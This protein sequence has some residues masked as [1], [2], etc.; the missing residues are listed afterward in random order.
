MAGKTAKKRGKAKSS[1]KKIAKKTKSKIK[2][3]VKST[4]R[5]AKK[6]SK[7]SKITKRKSK[8]APA[9]KEFFL[10]NG[11]KVKNYEQLAK[12]MENLEDHVF[13][14]HVNSERNDFAN[15][16]KDVFNDIALAKKISGVNKKDHLELV[17]YRRIV[18]G[19]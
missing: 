19:K 2:K 10:I 8:N 13:R 9:G 16:A 18:R 14:H 5:T 17:L 3:A 7:A 1:A 11:K 15:W 4:K 6:A 12:I